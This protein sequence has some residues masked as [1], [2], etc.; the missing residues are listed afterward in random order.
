MA[1]PSFSGPLVLLGAGKMGGALLEGWL[2]DGLDPGQVV[3]V[4]PSP[5]P[6]TAALIGERGI[7]LNPDLAGDFAKLP[8][9]A[10]ILLAVKPQM[11]A[12]AMPAVA[13]RA[14][15]GTL[16]VSIM[17]GKTLANLE[18]AFP[19][20]TAIVR[21]I[22]NTPAA[23]GRGASRSASSWARAGHVPARSMA[24]TAG[25]KKAGSRVMALT[26]SVGERCLRLPIPG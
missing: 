17:A 21:S 20:G 5:P 26:F 24:P 12:S 18:A 1:L 22:P 3:V 19:A 11:A 15:P 14:G 9:P 10:V 16:V 4:D 23:I 7:A 8:A 2:A 25:R 6:E 13:G